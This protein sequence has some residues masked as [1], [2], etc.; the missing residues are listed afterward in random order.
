[1][2]GIGAVQY[3]A[4]RC[5]ALAWGI[6]ALTISAAYFFCEWKPQKCENFKLWLQKKFPAF[7]GGKKKG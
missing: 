7:G 5:L 6:M 1:M 4:L 3:Y 2:E